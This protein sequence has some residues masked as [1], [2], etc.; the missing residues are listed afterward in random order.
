[1]EA[2]FTVTKLTH[3]ELVD[4]LSTA[5]YDNDSAILVQPSEEYEGFQLE[6]QTREDYWASVLEQGGSLWVYDLYD[7]SASKKD[8]EYHGKEGINW[9]ET[10]YRVVVNK[11][12]DIRGRVHI[13]GKFSVPTY[14]ITL[15]TLLAGINA[16][17]KESSSLVQEFFIEDTGDLY[18][19]Y[20]ILQIAVYGEIIYA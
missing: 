9:V 19:A 18:T 3:D 8:V 13:L 20:N 4:L 14:K 6:S 16:N 17:T 15:E 2:T 11:M 1:M 5:T 10:D 12:M 7:E